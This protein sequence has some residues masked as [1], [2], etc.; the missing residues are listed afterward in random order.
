MLA[1]IA[2]AGV[3]MVTPRTARASETRADSLLY[4]MA[5]EDMI[6]VFLYPQLA[7]NYRSV[8][9][10]LPTAVANAYGGIIYGS[11]HNAFGLFIHRPMANAF[12]QYR[13][14]GLNTAAYNT[15]IP[16]ANALTGNLQNLLYPSGQVFDLFWGNGK[17]GVGLRL[18]GQA[19]THTNV[20]NVADNT[21]KDTTFGADLNVGWSIGNA[22]AMHTDLTVGHTSNLG[23]LF[24]ANI[25]FRYLSKADK[26]AKPVFAGELQFGLYSP[27]KGKSNI[28]F[29]LPIKGGAH[30]DIIKNKLIAGLLVGLDLQMG[31]QGG[32]DMAFGMVVPTAEIATEYYALKWLSVRAAIKGGWGIQF[33]G[34]KSNHPT[35]N[36]LAFN[37]GLGFNID[38]F[39][40]DAA[41]SYNLWTSGPDFIGGKA[42]GLFGS[43]SLTYNF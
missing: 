27:K 40:I 25:G 34:S 21:A 23:T 22:T 18:Y 10:Y 3:A 28:Y 6:D 29:G 9:F 36:Q 35:T 42:P 41:I 39:I 43:V 12:N 31:K 5:F 15:L 4:N 33:S 19:K 11:D 24:G 32:G 7:V 8:S 2:V 1:L 13:L 26:V 38:S 14:W 30:L 16:G 37:T 17:V 20:G